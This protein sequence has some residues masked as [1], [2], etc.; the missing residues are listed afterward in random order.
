[1]KSQD[2]SISLFFCSNSL[3]AE[4]IS[5]CKDRSKKVNLN[6]ISLPCSGKANLLYLLKAIET[7]SDAVVL[8]SCKFG[9]CKFLQGNLRAQ[10][11]AE[12]V[13]SIIEETGLGK[14]R[15]RFLQI[16]EK[17]K[18]NTVCEEIESINKHIRTEIDLV[19]EKV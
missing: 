8:I 15:V 19:Q 11:R 13:D 2:I 18:V 10:K 17:N 14:G 4:E 1:M 12:E 7:G 5:V 9:E 16:D 3:T 6:F